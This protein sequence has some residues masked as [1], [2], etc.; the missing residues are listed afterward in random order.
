M[1]LRKIKMDAK[2]I[3]KRK[4]ANH[5]INSLLQLCLLSV[6]FLLGSSYALSFG[7]A[8][9]TVYGTITGSGADEI[10]ADVSLG[11]FS[12][13]SRID[14]RFT[15]AL[16]EDAH[17][18]IATITINDS[19][20]THDIRLTFLEKG[21]VVYEELLSDVSCWQSVELDIV[22]SSQKA[23]SS[24]ELK[25]AKRPNTRSNSIEMDNARYQSSIDN[26]TYFEEQYG[27]DVDK[28]EEDMNSEKNI[29]WPDMQKTKRLPADESPSLVS[30]EF[31]GGESVAMTAMIIII[32]FLCLLIIRT[33]CYYKRGL[34]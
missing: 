19:F 26:R 11:S 4:K 27:F 1:R 7:E 25:Q 3:T 15:D 30:E 10:A 33:C 13:E 6:I 29:E 8:P 28:L 20:E 31:S 14:Y 5:G 34:H 2:Q 32:L 21:A 18:F 12:I 23:S 17:N 16:N 24:S 9:V 22:L